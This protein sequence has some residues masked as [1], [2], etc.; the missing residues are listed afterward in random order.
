MRLRRLLL[1]GRELDFSQTDELYRA[2]GGDFSQT[3][4][5]RAIFDD[6]CERS[7]NVPQLLFCLPRREERFNLSRLHGL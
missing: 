6:L 3:T 4:V 2:N 7:K 1:I 5:K